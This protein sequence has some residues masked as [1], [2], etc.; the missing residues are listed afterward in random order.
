[1]NLMKKNNKVIIYISVL[2]V[3]L[4]IIVAAFFIWKKVNAVPKPDKLITDYVTCIKKKSYEKMYSMLDEQSKTYITKDEFIDRNKNIYEGIE[5]DN[6]KITVQKV[7]DGKS[8]M[9]KVFYAM[10][11]DTTAGKIEFEHNADFSKKRGKYF[12][13]WDHDLIFP[14]LQSDDKVRVNHSEAKRGS[15]LDREGKLLAGEGLA[16]SIGLVPNRLGEAPQDSIARLSALLDVPVESI[17]GKLD[18]GWVKEDSLVPVKVIEKIDELELASI[19]KSQELLD[20]IQLQQQLLEIPGVMISDV[21]VRTYPMK[22]A[23]AHLVG[24]VQNITAEELEEHKGKG[25]NSNSVIGKS[26]LEDLYE[27]E[28][29]GKDGSDIK[30]ITANDEEKQTMASAIKE[31]GKDIRLTIDAD[32]QQNLYQ[33]FQMDKSCSVAMNPK[34]GEVLAL[35]STPSFDSNDFIAGIS[36]AKWKELNENASKPLWNRFREAWCPG[37]TF[38]PIVSAIGLTTGTINPQE[39]FGNVGLSW[40]KDV[41]W[42]DYFVTTLKAYDDVVLENAL[43]YSDNIYFAKAALQIGADT[44][45]QQLKAIGFGETIPFEIGMSTSSY[46]NEETIDSEIQL[47]DSGYGQGQLLTDPLQLASSYSAFVNDGSIVQP[48]IEYKE[49]KLPA[50]WK[51]RVFTIESVDFVRNAMVQVIDNPQG[52]AAVC[53]TAGVALAGKTGTAEI[54]LSQDD[55]TGTELGWFAVLTADAAIENPILIISM[56]EGVKELGGSTYVVQ[57]DKIVLDQWFSKTR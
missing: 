25:Y 35:I 8:S 7:E 6:I 5:A 29:R 36:E 45:T 18:A 49:E 26:G 24:Y 10:S 16:S 2:V 52:T 32:M 15:I 11:M 3:V 9:K 46:S 33:Q 1:M 31:D 17:Q 27:D 38:K 30:I 56:V 34:T 43:I 12:L 20:E 22:E 50:Y 54:K 55:T 51:E 40:Q 47:A 42:G 41:S 4:V 48:Y 37:S 28:L 39:N 57:K 14:K 44:L 19:E 21:E 53:Q 23:A 13:R